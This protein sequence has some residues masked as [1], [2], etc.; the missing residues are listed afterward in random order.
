MSPARPPGA[1]RRGSGSA[2]E[3][4]SLGESLAHHLEP[5]DV[6]ALSGPLGA[7]KTR[8]VVGLARG[9]DVAARVR[10]PSFTLVAEYHGRLPLLHVDLYRLAPTEADGLGLEEA[11]ERGVLAVE[12]GEKLPTWLRA[13]ALAIEFEIVSETERALVARAPEPVRAG[14]A[15]GGAGLGEAPASRPRAL[16]EAWTA[17]ARGQALR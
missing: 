8:F 14:E 15:P 9:L 5:G 12:W 11:L 2:A 1:E 10:S 17:A 13:R 6:L 3:T 4:E 7:G 16:L